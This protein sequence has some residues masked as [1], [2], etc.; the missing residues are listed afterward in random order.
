M[1]DVAWLPDIVGPGRI[2]SIIANSARR[3]NAQPQRADGPADVLDRLGDLAPAVVVGLGLLGA[4]GVGLAGAGERPQQ[5][6]A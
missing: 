6:G 1:D 5:G 4:A 3:R 2:P